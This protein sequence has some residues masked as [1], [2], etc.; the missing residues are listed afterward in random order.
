MTAP[1]QVDVCIIG[2]GLAG[3]RAAGRLS[4][5]GRSI[6]V[7]EARD[8]VGGRTMG[9]ELCGEPVDLGGQWVGPTQHRVLALCAE[10]GL[11]LYPQY[12]EGLRLLDIGGR[13]R[14]YR[15]TVP[16]MSLLAALDAGRAVRGLNRAA[17]TIDPAAP[18]LAAGA[19]DLDRMTLDQW[20]RRTLFTRDGRRVLDIM[21]RAIFTCEAHEISLLAALTT[22]AGAGSLEV[23]A[24]VQGDGAQKLKIRGGAFQLAARLA[25]RLPPGALVLQA[26]VHAVEPSETGVT[27]RHAGGEIRAGRVIVA[28]APAL[29]ARIDFGAALPPLRQ[30]LHSRMPMGSV[31]KALVA[32]ERPFWR[33]RGWSGEVV[34]DR[35]PFGPVMDA[36]PPGSPHGF[37]VGFFDGGHSRALSGAPMDLRRA[38][39][40][41]ALQRYFGPEAATPI[42]YVDK[43]WIAEPWSLGG[44]AGFTAPGTLTTCGPALR[45]PCGRIHWSG[46]ETATRWIGYLDGALEAGER[47]A[48]EVMASPA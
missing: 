22:I 11:E 48:A 24:E 1:A 44:Y 21:T 20:L 14:R 15:G 42:G 31:I 32:Y 38:A 46:T 17:A 39:A 25:D 37:L 41:K 12:A 36:T 6:C 40:V 45:L 8:R 28:L 3:L 4:E 27:V 18:W 35:G 43:D 34:S 26:P 23:Q 16:R 5:G 13:L 9:G 2:A 10:L 29:A 7:L 47:A 19:A 30:Q 33:A